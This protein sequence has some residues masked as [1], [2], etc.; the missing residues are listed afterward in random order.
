MTKTLSGRYGFFDEANARFGSETFS[1]TYRDDR[2]VVLDSMCETMRPEMVRRIVYER[3]ADGRPLRATIDLRE[4][5][6]VS[7]VSVSFDKAGMQADYDDR[8]LGRVSRRWDFDGIVSFGTHAV[9]ND[10]WYAQLYDHAIG[11]VQTFKDCPV[12]SVSENGDSGLLIEAVTVTVEH[13][14]QEPCRTIAGTSGHH[15]RIAF[16]SFS[17]IDVW[18]REED[19]LLLRLYWAQTRTEIRLEALDE[20]RRPALPAET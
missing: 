7:S 18:V 4:A 2:S 9:I 12:S 10:A 5:A 17:P 1:L 6:G 8:R 3:D 14:A 15:Y 20:D 19:G 16:A 13:V 11:G